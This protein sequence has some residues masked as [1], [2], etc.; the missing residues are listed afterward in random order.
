M[1]TPLG[2]LILTTE[3]ALA[4]QG[5]RRPATEALASIRHAAKAADARLVALL[6]EGL[7]SRLATAEERVALTKPA[8]ARSPR[9]SA[10]LP[11]ASRG[12]V[13]STVPDPLH[14]PPSRVATVE[15]RRSR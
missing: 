13:P 11:R 1:T 3:R 15:G 6:R 7:E 9:P 8:A 4:V 14:R 12:R 10:A 5:D 2:G